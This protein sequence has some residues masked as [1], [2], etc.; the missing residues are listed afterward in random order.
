MELV[1]NIYAKQYPI[2]PTLMYDAQVRSLL[3][4]FCWSIQFCAHRC[5]N[6]EEEIL[7]NNDREQKR[8]RIGFYD[9]GIFRM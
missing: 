7:Y 6:D 8:E 5:S 3:W 9:N 1:S 4:R 2:F